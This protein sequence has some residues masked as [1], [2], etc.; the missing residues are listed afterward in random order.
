VDT[1]TLTQLE[2]LATEEVTYGFYAYTEFV[3][4]AVHATIGQ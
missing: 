1:Y 2:V 3:S 4:D